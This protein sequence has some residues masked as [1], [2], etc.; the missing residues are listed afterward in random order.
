[1]FVVAVES[2]SFV[3]FLLIIADIWSFLLIFLTIS[4][5]RLNRQVNTYSWLP[6]QLAFC[7]NFNVIYSIFG[8]SIGP[9][10]KPTVC[11][12]AIIDLT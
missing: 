5:L 4:A 7:I 11:S 2:K 8:C 10:E 6:Y 1:M 9:K 12:D 3:V